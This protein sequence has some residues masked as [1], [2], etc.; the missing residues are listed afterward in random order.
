VTRDLRLDVLR[1]LSI[2][3]V[4][5]I[6]IVSIV[7][8]QI[9]FQTHGTIS[10]IVKITNES[11]FW[12]VPVFFMLSGALLLDKSTESMQEFYIKR[13]NKIL[14]PTLFWSAFF[15]F[16]L[17]MYKHFALSN[18]LG[19]IFKGKPFYHLWFMYAIIGLY[20]F[21]PFFRILL[22]NLSESQ[23]RWLIIFIFT[24]TVGT[25]Y[26][27]NYL[28]NQDTI[29]SSFL[30]Y[31]GYFI[32]GY[33]FY[34]NQNDY[35]KYKNFYF[36]IFVV[37]TLIFSILEI[38]LHYFYNLKFPIVAYYSPFIALEAIL[39]FLYFITCNSN[40][41]FSKIWILLSTLSFGV[42]LIH[43]LFI[44]FIEHYVTT[45]QQSVYLPFYF[46]L[47][48]IGSYLSVYIL[49]KIKYLNNIV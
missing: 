46:V 17:F 32:L 7:D 34:N 20:L 5:L 41:K 23:T 18:V 35:A 47:V 12:C 36:V 26:V 2:F 3:A 16:Y 43:P 21:T 10:W 40:I 22:A 11:L 8:S 13:M 19:A 31:I 9:N 29:F 42:Y 6:H 15:L 27:G 39:L 24:I 30:T 25:D 37:S 28:H 4:I 49:K 44:L 45:I 33:Y 1:S 38:L 48:L 14:L